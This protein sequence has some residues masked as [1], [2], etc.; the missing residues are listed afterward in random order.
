LTFLLVNE[1]HDWLTANGL[2]PGKVCE[3]SELRPVGKIKLLR[4]KN[5]PVW[6]IE[7]IFPDCC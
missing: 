6:K 4:E 1:I 5:V 2:Q 3:A 7:R